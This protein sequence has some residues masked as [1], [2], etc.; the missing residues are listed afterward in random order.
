MEYVDIMVDEQCTSLQETLEEEA[1]D[2]NRVLYEEETLIPNE[3]AKIEN[4]MHDQENVLYED[5]GENEADAYTNDQDCDLDGNANH[6]DN[7]FSP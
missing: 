5:D 4:V 3:E 7:D 1:E 6:D 2:D